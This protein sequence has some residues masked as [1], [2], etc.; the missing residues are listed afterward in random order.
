MPAAITPETLRAAAEL[1]EGPV[2]I[3]L[4][5]SE[6]APLP[7]DERLQRANHVLS[8]LPSLEERH[9][10]TVIAV[11]T[12][13]LYELQREIG[14]AAPQWDITR[15]PE[16]QTEMEEVEKARQAVLQ[17]QPQPTTTQETVLQHGHEALHTLRTGNSLHQSV[18]IGGTVFAL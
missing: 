12:A 6:Q 5:G 18:M 2:R 13:S 14:A 8:L 16:L 4:R 11:T 1:G 17:L 15:P 9:R 3:L 10:K 7:R